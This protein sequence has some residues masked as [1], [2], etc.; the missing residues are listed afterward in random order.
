MVYFSEAN[1]NSPKMTEEKKQTFF[2]YT[3]VGFVT[4][5]TLMLQIVETRIMSVVS[6]Y[7]LAFFVISIAM[8]G[9]TAG[10]IWVYLKPNIF[11]TDNLRTRLVQTTSAF[12]VVTA[13]SLLIQSSL[14]ID[15]IESASSIIVWLELSLCLAAPFFFSG[16]IVS[17]VL[18]RSPY[19]T[20]RVYGI[21]LIGAAIG[22]LVV[23]VLL[24]YTDGPSAV[25]WIAAIIAIAA[26]LFSL[27][28]LPHETSTGQYP[29]IERILSRPLIIF[30][31]LVLA[32][33]LNGL[34][35]Y[36][37][38][39]LIIKG[40]P[41]ERGDTLLHEEWNSFSRIAAY[42]IGAGPPRLWGRSPV[43]PAYRTQQYLLNIDGEAGTFMFRFDGDRF[44]ASF[45]KYDV[46]NFAYYLP[47]ISESAVIG[48]GSGR[49]VLSA[50]IFGVDQVTG[51]EVNPIFI[52]LLSREGRFRSFSQVKDLPGVS[53]VVDEARSW[54]AQTNT[55]FDLV[56]M[57]MIDTWAAT[58]AGAFSLSENG[59][60][61]REA[62]DIFL[63]SLKNTGVFTVSRWHSPENLDESGRMVSLATDLLLDLGIA[64][65]RNHIYVVTA[66]NIATM[67]L[68]KREF[69]ESQINALD[70]AAT[71][72]RYKVIVHPKFRASTE[73]L[74][75]I[76]SSN[77]RDLLHQYTGSLNLDLTPTSDDRPFFFNQMNL[78]K[79]IEAFKTAL[80]ATS[81]VIKGNLW[82]TLTLLMIIAISLFLVVISII[83]PLKSAIKPVSPR[84]VVSGTGYF[85]LIGCGFMFIEIGLLQR[86]SVFLG[87]PVYALSV[88]LFT[89]ICA[90]G[91]GA[92]VSDVFELSS[93]KRRLGWVLLTS[94]YLFG[95]PF[96]MPLVLPGY[97]QQA[98]MLRALVSVVIIAPVGFLMGF[99]F[100]T[101][102]KLV[103]AID[104][105]PTPWFWGVN[106]AAGV[107][108]SSLAVVISIA[109]G[110][111]ATL[112]LGATCYLLL[113]IPLQRL[114]A[115]R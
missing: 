112:F 97:E 53:L 102:M 108:A 105:Q 106:G 68:T 33:T 107:L 62:W 85:F 67:V 47:G 99:G 51:I 73:I 49:D 13:L 2:F 103:N 87:H 48:V 58:G 101:G 75:R 19:K 35:R 15:K 52:K 54:F 27:S 94:T 40:S 44:N 22:C 38:Q 115:A 50:K 12:S 77:N 34:T 59:L 46:T 43:M 14:A 93:S 96:W 18:T 63:S 39:P 64:S 56:Q 113:A 78:S 30:C 69:T 16:I 55:R 74:E 6:W 91:L 92:L 76:V 88:V 21:D 71:S 25:L 61:T 7:Y 82:A 10:A 8:F 72:L 3:G 86:I 60:Y 31:V 24:Q 20:G 17:L 29:V 89:I 26:K 95:L 37:A 11:R 9:L 100:P 98:I 110:I 32:A 104:R 79:P 109:F 1:S 57:S 90:T 114:A 45:L 42:N 5:A 65:P 4:A 70:S 23:L 41:N 36:G 83:W 80:S 66:G 81:G 111:N 28:G 84:L